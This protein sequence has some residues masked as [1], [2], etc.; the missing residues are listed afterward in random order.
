MYPKKIPLAEK[1]RR[2]ASLL[3]PSGSPRAQNG[4]RMF[5]M[6][7]GATPTRVGVGTGKSVHPGESGRL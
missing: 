3:A 1:A 2:G 7:E 6:P 4:G 5:S